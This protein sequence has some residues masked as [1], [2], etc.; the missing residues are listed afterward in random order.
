MDFRISVIPGYY[1]ENA[2]IRILDPRSAPESIAALKLAPAIT[3]G[4]SS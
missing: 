2:V 1:G 3:S 4:C